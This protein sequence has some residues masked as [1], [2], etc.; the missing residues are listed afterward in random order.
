VSLTDYL[1]SYE[2]IAGVG[3]AVVPAVV[4]YA[5][6]KGYVSESAA[7]DVIAAVLA[8]GA[9]V[10]SVTKNSKAS[11]VASVA[12]MPGTIVDQN[13][14]RIVITDPDLARASRESATGV[15]G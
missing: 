3:R 5:V 14:K 1:P 8:V 11:R 15:N 6:A 10:W 13:G 12:A 4:A 2:Q 9:A 7:A